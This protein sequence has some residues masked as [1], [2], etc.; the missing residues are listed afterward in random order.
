MWERETNE[1]LR[2]TSEMTYSAIH[3]FILMMMMMMITIITITTIMH[4]LNF[5]TPWV[6][7]RTFKFEDAF[8]LNSIFCRRRF[9]DAINCKC[10]YG[11]YNGLIFIVCLIFN[12]I[13]ILAKQIV[14]HA[15]F[16]KFPFGLLTIW[17]SDPWYNLL[18]RLK[19]FFL[20][21]SKAHNFSY[22]LGRPS[23]R[24]REKFSLTGREFALTYSSSVGLPF[25]A[26]LYQT[27]WK[28]TQQRK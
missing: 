3:V 20:L 2:H 25:Q 19:T 28:F 21:V 4:I 22:L 27:H 9:L 16:K 10:K 26:C 17:V 18:T 14:Q 8:A 7:R 6:V 24:C 15:R 23:S 11:K 12:K 13:I 5:R 1:K